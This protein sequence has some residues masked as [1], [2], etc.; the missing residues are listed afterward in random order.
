VR[1]RPACFSG[2]RS[3]VACG[4]EG[5]N[6]GDECG[7]FSGLDPG[8]SLAAE[9]ADE[10]FAGEEER[11][12]IAYFGDVEF[13]AFGE[14]DD[15]AGVDDVFVGDVHFVDA[16]V[17]VEPEIALAAAA[18]E[19]EPFTGKETFHQ[20]L[21]FGFDLDAHARGDK[22]RALEEDRLV[23]QV[24]VLHVTEG[25]RCDTDF[26]VAIFSGEFV[27][28][29][30]LACKQAFEAAAHFCFHDQVGVHG[31]H[32]R[33][34]HFQGLAGRDVDGQVTEIRLMVE[35]VFKIGL[36]AVHGFALSK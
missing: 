4:S 30:R 10:A 14:G 22:G 33:A 1:G 7:D 27:N 19:K 6:P 15:V 13:E 17:A 3:V 26:T 11:F 5:V 36:I 9:S 8:F 29:E 12:V 18:D 25:T 32:G 16:A 20:A 34:F 2:V 24:D 23:V 28:E 35:A 21:P 31:G